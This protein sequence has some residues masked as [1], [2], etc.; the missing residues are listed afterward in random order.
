MITWYDLYTWKSK[1]LSMVDVQVLNKG[2][3]NYGAPNKRCPWPKAAD[4][5]AIRGAHRLQSLQ[6]WHHDF[7]RN[8]LSFHWQS[9]ASTWSLALR[10]AGLPEARAAWSTHRGSRARRL[11]LCGNLRRSGLSFL[12]LSRLKLQLAQKMSKTSMLSIGQRFAFN[13]PHCRPLHLQTFVGRLFATA[14]MTLPWCSWRMPKER[15]WVW[16]R[17]THRMIISRR[18]SAYLMPVWAAQAFGFSILFA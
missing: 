2:D 18:G 12:S 8:C 14:R 7:H 4:T 6:S 5:S 3:K 17:S 15:C 11:C 13:L 10:F 9:A 16:L 1:D